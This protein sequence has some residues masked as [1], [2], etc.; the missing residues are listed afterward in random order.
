MFFQVSTVK[1]SNIQEL[2]VNPATSEVIVEF[3]SG[4]FITYTNV[5]RVAIDDL[6][7]ARDGYS[8]GGWVNANCSKDSE[9]ICDNLDACSS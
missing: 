7:Y 5:N 9:T 3:K 1:S 6:L 4:E 8:L 2:M